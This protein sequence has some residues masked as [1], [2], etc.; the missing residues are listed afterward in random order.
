M[1]YGLARIGQQPVEE[2]LGLLLGVGIYGFADRGTGIVV[3]TGLHP[4][5]ISTIRAA[6]DASFRPSRSHHWLP[7]RV[8]GG[9]RRAK[10]AEPRGVPAC[11]GRPEW[12]ESLSAERVDMPSCAKFRETRRLGGAQDERQVVGRCVHMN[13]PILVE[14]A[15]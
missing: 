14:F 5:F 1:F 3:D 4:Y 8:P 12:W 13:S 9:V 2:A 11:G 15:C 7:P 10:P 6:A